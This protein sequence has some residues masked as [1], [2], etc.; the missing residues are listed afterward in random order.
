VETRVE[1]NIIHYNGNEFSVDPACMGINMTITSLLLGLMLIA[2]YQK[3]IGKQVKIIHTV[4]LL[5][6]IMGLNIFS[7]LIRILCLVQFNI[8]P[9]TW[10][11]ELTGIIC[12]IIYVMIPSSFIV[13]FIVRRFG[14]PS[15][16]VSQQTMPVDR[17]HY[18]FHAIILIAFVGASILI[19]K[20]DKYEA[21]PIGPTPL[22]NGYDTKRVDW[23]IVK[24][25]NAQ[26][27]VYIKS[28][29][30]FYYADH[31]P[32]ICWR[33]SGY[34]LRQVKTIDIESQTVYAAVLEKGN[35]KLYT[36]WWYDNGTHRTI[37]QFD[38][39]WNVLMGKSKYS[40]VNI[41]ASEQGILEKEIQKVQYDNRFK[42]IL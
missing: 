24:L 33:G 40:L 20:N 11:H 17:R 14:K 36:A 25:E 39:R 5:A 18:F 9:G 35:E 38:W 2:F 3:R 8:L 30:D 10:M 32:M 15:V 41:T 12:L 31:N 13:R 26:S 22:V 1:G 23:S 7:N 37:D 16:Q 19:S 29:R 27:L 42:S 28:I 4:S 21:M 6:V 34:E